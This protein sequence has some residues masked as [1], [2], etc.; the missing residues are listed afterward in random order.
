MIIIKSQNG[1]RISE[2]KCVEIR[3]SIGENVDNYN[4]VVK[5]GSSVIILGAY[6]SEARAKEVMEEIED[7]IRQLYIARE[8]KLNVEDF[9]T[10]KQKNE[11]ILSLKDAA[12][13]TMPKG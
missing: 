11:F 3:K 8:F 9:S 12:I 6:K 13:Y 4:I 7:H 5:D 2:C 10:I 1:N